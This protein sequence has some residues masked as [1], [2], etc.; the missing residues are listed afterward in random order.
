MSQLFKIKKSF[1]FI[2]L[3]YLYA[4]S[5]GCANHIAFYDQYAYTQATSLKVDLQ[6][7]AT[8]SSTVIFTDAKADIDKVNT[9][10]QKALEY[11]KGRAKNTL[12][13]DQYAI[14]L[15]G[16]GFYKSFLKTWDSQG[17]LTPAGANEISKSIGDLM[18][19]I[20]KLE[21]GKTKQNQ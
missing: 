4:A 12:S 9:Q 14:L 5:V 19:Q 10:I 13:T 1:V 18:D 16:N 8:E 2:F 17:K 21:S 3:L 15:S 11:S 7:L 20:I 6:N